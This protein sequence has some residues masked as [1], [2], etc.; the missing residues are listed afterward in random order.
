MGLTHKRR[1][2]DQKDVSMCLA[3][4]DMSQI[5]C[6]VRNKWYEALL[7]QVNHCRVIAW[8]TSQ[9]ACLS[10]CTSKALSLRPKTL[11]RTIE[12]MTTSSGSH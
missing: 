3:F 11:L 12:V 10:T 6:D 8:H 9:Y 4:V 1:I 7:L 2:I 5:F